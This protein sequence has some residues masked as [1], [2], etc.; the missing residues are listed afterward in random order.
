[1]AAF[2]DN[3]A[4]VL[5]VT[6]TT[7]LDRTKYNV[8]H[9]HAKWP[10]GPSHGSTNFLM[11]IEA[12]TS[13]FKSLHW[14]NVPV[15]TARVNTANVSG[16]TSLSDD[17]WTG[18]GAWWGPDQ[19]NPP[20]RPYVNGTADATTGTTGD[21]SGNTS[22]WNKLRIGQEKGSTS[23]Y[24]VWRGYI[25]EVSGWEVDTEANAAALIAELATTKANAVTGT[26]ATLRFYAPLIS[27]A[28]VETGDALTNNG[29]TFDAEDPGLSGGSPPASTAQ[30]IAC[31]I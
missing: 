10:T 25:A 22:N 5:S 14:S 6:L 8:W 9:L 18:C 23:I 21:L 12:D 27:D 29:V 28:T 26:G 11:Q 7:G 2:F 17:T 4:D 16:T 31:I 30:V 24:S 20:R 3:G 13:L 19:S 15:L 1:M